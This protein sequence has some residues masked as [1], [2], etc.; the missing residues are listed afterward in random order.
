V[1]YAGPQAVFRHWLRPPYQVDGWRVD[2]ANMLARHGADQLEREVWDGIRKAVKAENP[3]AYLLGENFF[4]GSPQLQGDQLDATMNYAGFT[5]PLWYWLGK[6]YFYQHGQPHYAES[7]LPWPT[8]ALADT[9]QAFRAAIPWVIAR[10][11]FNLLGSHDTAR[12]LSVVNGDEAR[13]R[14]AV[15]FL[16]TYPGVPCVYYGDEIGMRA[17]DSLAARDCMEWDRAKWDM[18]LREFYQRLIRL[19]RESPALLDG[20]FQVLAVEE[21]LLATL[22]DSDEEQIIVVGNRGPAIRPAGGLPVAHGGIPDGMI[23]T[24]IFSG[25]QA[26]VT[27]GHLPLAALPAGVQVWRSVRAQGGI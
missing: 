15:A 5:H 7:A 13:N 16:M 14:L 4:D 11:Q 8:Q 26:V 19:R 23:F 6:F 25:A 3:Q 24:E 10:Q 20:G 9:W 18:N 1:I 2:V 27:N 22:R 12:I 17:S 21:N